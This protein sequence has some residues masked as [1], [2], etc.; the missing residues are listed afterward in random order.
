MAGHKYESLEVI[1][2]NEQGL[3]V[4]LERCI[5]TELRRR[6]Y[7]PARTCDGTAVAGQ[8]RLK[9]ADIFGYGCMPELSGRTSGCS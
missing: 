1:V 2:D 8:V 7:E 5:L 9:Y 6:S 4:T 3:I